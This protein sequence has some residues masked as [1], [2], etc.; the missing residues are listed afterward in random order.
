MTNQHVPALERLYGPTASTQAVRYG[1]LAQ[2]L[3]E[4][5]CHLDGFGSAPGRTELAGNHTDHN[6]GRVLAAAVDVDAVAAVS[7]RDDGRII[8]RSEGFDST[9]EVD[10]RDGLQPVAAERGSTSALL[11]G[12]AAALQRRNHRVGGF[13]AWVASEVPPGCGLSSSAAIEVLIGTILSGL[14]NGASIAAQ[15][16]A[17]AGQEAENQ[18]FG[19]PCGLMDQM[20]SAQG[21]VVT[22]DFEEPL[23]PRVARVDLTLAGLGHRLAVVDTGGSHADLTDDY[24]SIPAEMRAV[25][26]RLGQATLRGIS[27][28]TLLAEAPGIRLAL[29]DRALLRALHFAWEDTRV[30][31]QVQALES[32]DTAAFLGLVRASGLSSMRWLQNVVPAGATRDQG[33]ALAL[34]LTEDFLQGRGA[35]RVHG[36]GFAG[37]IQVWLPDGFEGA[38]RALMAPIFGADC[39]RMLALRP[40][41]AVWIDAPRD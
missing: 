16:L 13:D 7:R 2:R 5:G 23:A 1:R 14:Y 39:V 29:G 34:A 38:Y 31:A 12:V 40:Q 3:R 4:A 21:G 11:R 17:L 6:R 24:A 35:C 36:G 20:A 32:G 10:L 27:A 15:D 25:A 8:L 9:F 18:H 28:Q 22:I 26:Q 41:G 33:M 30:P 19:K 37:A